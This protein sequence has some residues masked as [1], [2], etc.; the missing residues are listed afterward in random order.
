MS[1]S[2]VDN[3][4]SFDR[5]GI[6]KSEIDQAIILM[7]AF[8][9]KYA[10]VENPELIETLTPDDIFKEQTSEVGDF[11]YRIE[12]QLKP[13]GHLFLFSNVYR[14]IRAQIADFKDV[15]YVVVDRKQSLAEKVDAPWNRIRGM[16]G[17]RHIAKKIIFCFN[18]ETNDVLPIFKT[19]D[20]EH[21][22]TSITGGKFPAL[23]GGMSLGE[24]YQFLISE[25]L[26]V[27]NQI[28][29][30]EHWELPYFS[31]FLYDI[32]PPPR[33]VQAPPSNGKRTS[34][35]DKDKREKQHQMRELMTL[36]TELRRK[37]KISAEELR[38]YRK[39]WEDA[40]QNRKSLVDRLTILNS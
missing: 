22:F 3:A 24:K 4:K 8:R 18:F 10:F 1:S 31:R 30:T 32:Y 15:L 38:L 19:S 17:D 14:Q 5:L 7:K 13:I 20:L 36:L 35:E 40:P 2:V 9:E 39:R 21:F 28:P 25:I 11:F 12:Y 27:K 34:R 23:Y 29:E 6:K 37:N 16:G 33:I 26:Q